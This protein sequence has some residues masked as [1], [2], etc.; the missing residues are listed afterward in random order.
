MPYSYI[1]MGA[2]TQQLM[3][4]ASKTMFTIAQHQAQ[5][6]LSFLC[7]ELV[8]K[9]NIA[10][11]QRIVGV[12]ISSRWCDQNT[13]ESL[14]TSSGWLFS[15]SLTVAGVFNS[16][17]SPSCPRL[18]PLMASPNPT[19]GGIQTQKIC[20]QCPSECCSRQLNGS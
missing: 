11:N 3:P 13:S 15:C 7:I 6:C 5:L 9:W 19:S 8:M 18:K 17:E 14:S 10:R 1:L 4:R 12:K 2:C 16:G 20:E